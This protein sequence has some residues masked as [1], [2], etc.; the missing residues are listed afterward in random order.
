MHLTF[1][2]EGPALLVENT[3]R[4]LVIADM[5]FGIETDFARRGV[6]IPSQSAERMRRAIGC[7]EATEPDLLVLLGDIK[8]SIPMTTRQEYREVPEALSAFRERVPIRVAPGNHDGGIEKF[9]QEGELLPIRGAVIDDVG[10][11]HGHTHPDGE[12]LG[13]PLVIGHL[14]PMVSLQDEVGCALRDRAYISTVIDAECIGVKGL[15]RPIDLL[16]M[17]AFNEFSG[18]DVE[19]LAD[20]SLGPL[21]RCMQMDKAEVFLTDGT[22]LGPLRSLQS[23]GDPLSPGQASAGDH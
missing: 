19:R 8:H 22:Y 17:P 15:K 7:I 4:V 13:H 20:T 18:F 23:G 16:V 6:H 12:L 9:L 21:A 3:M 10:Y 11:L 5:H 14:H 2:E 1:V